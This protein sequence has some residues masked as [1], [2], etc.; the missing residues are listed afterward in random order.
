[1]VLVLF[2][3]LIV[4]SSVVLQ[5]Y[6]RYLLLVNEQLLKVSELLV[7]VNP[8]LLTPLLKI[9]QL[10]YVV[11]ELMQISPELLLQVLDHLIRGQ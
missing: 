2:G 8:Y 5:E 3:L 11:P 7:L 10:E 6:L 1:M 9:S 4:Y